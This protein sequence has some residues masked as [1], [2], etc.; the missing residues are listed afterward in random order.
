MGAKSFFFDLAPSSY[1][2]VPTDHGAEASQPPSKLKQVQPPLRAVVVTKVVDKIFVD[3]G[4]N[5]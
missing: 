2:P 4:K 1:E 5:R 3:K